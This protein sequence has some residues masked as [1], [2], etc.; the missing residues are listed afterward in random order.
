MTGVLYLIRLKSALSPDSVEVSTIVYLP[1]LLSPTSALPPPTPPPPP[2]CKLHIYQ[3]EHTN[4]NKRG[5][6]GRRND[7]DDGDNMVIMMI[8][9]TIQSLVAL[10]QKVTNERIYHEWRF[11]NLLPHSLEFIF[12]GDLKTFVS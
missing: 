8:I 10:Q 11:Q 2:S 4:N 12:Q 3:K 6:G 7:S 9:I 5:R 1:P